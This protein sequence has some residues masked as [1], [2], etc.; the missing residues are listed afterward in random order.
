MDFL[1]DWLSHPEYWFHQK[2]ETDI[3]LTKT[4]EHLLNEA[5]N[6]KETN[7]Q[8]HLLHIILN[9]QLV[10][11]IYRNQSANHIILYHLE[12]AL[13]IHFYIRSHYDV[14]TCF[15]G[16]EWMFWGLPI[17][18]SNHPQWIITLIQKTWKKL[19]L[20]EVDNCIVILK[21][22]LTAS[23]QRIPMSQKPFLEYFENHEKGS[24]DA[25]SE[26][27]PILDYFPITIEQ[28]YSALE[29]AFQHFFQRH[30]ISSCI[31]SLS[32]GV[33]SM[34]CSFILK[35]INIPTV[36]VYIDYCNRS[37]DEAKFIQ[38]WCRYL[39]L[40]LYIRCIHEIQR[41]PCMQYNMRSIYE[42]YTRNI[43]YQCY[44]DAWSNKGSPYVILGHNEDDC[45]ENI[46]TN[47]CHQNKYDNLEGMKPIM[48]IDGI[49]FCRPMLS[50]PKRIIYEEAQ[51]MGIPYLKDSTPSWSQ[52]G[53]IRDTIRPALNKWDS[54]MIPAMFQ[55]S[56]T[57]TDAEMFKD[58]ILNKWNLQTTY[59]SKYYCIQFD[60]NNIKEL[61]SQSLWYSYFESKKIHI[62]QKSIKHFLESLSRAI[63]KKQDMNCLLNKTHTVS[64]LYKTNQMYINF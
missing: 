53:Q 10:R 19:F 6:E 37:K 61:L 42:S 30:S 57:L 14:Y 7:V 47:I 5:W 62:K 3:Y 43:R 16:A 44:K 38:E 51:R 48:E 39:Q 56:K 31:I 1:K 9:D 50:I 54:R 46:L 34:L 4:Y 64:Y 63:D 8:H 22:F 59:T 18:H 26:Y 52:R 49:Q 35:K 20:T 27:I 60:K 25:I 13:H 32:G 33:D 41:K 2:D 58:I 29:K 17:R 45:F 28:N 24:M 40:P 23:F 21:K 36:A 11:H 55:L 12:K 15:S